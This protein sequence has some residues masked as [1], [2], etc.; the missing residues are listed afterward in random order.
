MEFLQQLLA[1]FLDRFKTNNP[2][3]FAIVAVVLL[4][5]NYA[6]SNA[7]EWGLLDPTT[8]PWITN[9]IDILT[10]ILIVIT[11]TRTVKFMSGPAQL[12]IIDKESIDQY[13]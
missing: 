12:K 7:I 9:A 4:T 1:G 3:V 13:D 5:I 6:A 2:V 11:G 8:S 10:Q